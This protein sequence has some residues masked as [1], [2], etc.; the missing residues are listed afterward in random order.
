MFRRSF[1]M[2]GTHSEQLPQLD[3]YAEALKH[4]NSVTPLRSGQFKGQR[5]LGRVRRYTR[6]MIRLDESAAGASPAAPDVVLSFYKNDIIRFKPNNTVVLDTCNWPSISTMQFFADILRRTYYKPPIIRKKN[7][8]YYYTTDSEGNHSYYLITPNAP[9]TVDLSANTATGGDSIDTYVLDKSE[10]FKVRKGYREFTQYAHNCLAMSVAVPV[11]ENNN[12][13]IPPSFVRVTPIMF[14]PEGRVKD[15]VKMIGW[16]HH[17]RSDIFEMINSTEGSADDRLVR[18]YEAF[19]V[20]AGSAKSY[21]PWSL[22]RHDP[23]EIVCGRDYFDMIFTGMLKLHYADRLFHKTTVTS[24]MKAI[25]DTRNYF[26]V[27]YGKCQ[28]Q[29][30]QTA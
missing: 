23:P 20:I 27:R 12:G 7:R 19:K 26:F 15:S 18:Y 17:L 3:S 28:Q 16:Q 11:P 14:P 30:G 9:V 1:A 25:P 21:M 24:P 29:E 4:Y 22:V 13:R 10:M 2:N 5:P 8:I 6:S